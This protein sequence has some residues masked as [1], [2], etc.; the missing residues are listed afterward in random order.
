MAYFEPRSFIGNDFKSCS[1]F[2]QKSP[3]LGLDCLHDFLRYKRLIIR[4]RFVVLFTTGFNQGPITYISNIV[5]RPFACMSTAS[6]CCVGSVYVVY[7][8]SNVE[9]RLTH[10]FPTAHRKCLVL[11]LEKPLSSYVLTGVVSPTY[12][13]WHRLKSSHLWS[14]G[15]DPWEFQRFE[16]RKGTKNAN[17]RMGSGI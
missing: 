17:L 5:I 1:I 16:V 6:K 14:L 7:V 8:E 3:R 15:N 13:C 11:E 4:S 9:T 10:L 12:P 2:L